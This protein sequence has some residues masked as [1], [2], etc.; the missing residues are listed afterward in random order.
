MTTLD[1][2]AAVDAAAIAQFKGDLEGMSDEGIAAAKEAAQNQI[3]EIEP[4]L[5]ALCAEQRRRAAN[6][7]S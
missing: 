5:E 2:A 6:A 3:D 4:W 1:I 7:R